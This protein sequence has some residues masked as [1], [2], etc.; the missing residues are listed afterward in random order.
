MKNTH[1]IALFALAMT[2]YGCAPYHGIGRENIE[3]SFI[4]CASMGGLKAIEIRGSDMYSK[5][6]A[7]CK[8]GYEILIG[9]ESK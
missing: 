9:G 7:I 3:K 6:T 8:N 2:L 5:P 4:A 1:K